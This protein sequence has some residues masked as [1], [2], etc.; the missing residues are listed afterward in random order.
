MTDT[1][2]IELAAKGA[3]INAI[4]DPNGVWRNC[5]RLPPGFNIFDAKPWNPLED[6][7][8]ALRLAVKLE[9][10]INI[11]QGNVQVRYKEDMPLVFVGCGIDK[12]EAT[13][14][15]ICRAA[16]EIGKVPM[17]EQQFEAAMRRFKFERE[18]GDYIMER[19]NLELEKGMGLFKLMDSG[20]F[21]QGFKEKMT[22]TQN[23]QR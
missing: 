19:Y 16:A 22:G 3:R 21:Y 18:Y 23:E 6:D 9:M 8:D 17:T 13:R 1:E 11:S 12:N 2:L 15:A 14:L 4:K 5:T 10:K 7:G 20:D